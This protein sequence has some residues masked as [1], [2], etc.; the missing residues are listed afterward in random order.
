MAVTMQETMN[1]IRKYAPNFTPKIGMILGSGLGSIAD[2]LTDTIAVPYQAIPGLQTG[3]VQGH[4]SLM[5]MGNLGGVP[6]VCMKGRLHLYEGTPYESVRTFVR[7]IRNLGA[8]T[9]VI[10]GAAGSLRPEVG[11]GEVMLLNDHINFQPGNPLVGPNDESIGPRFMGMEDAYDEELRTRFL[12]VS[13]R[14]NIPVTEGVYLSLIGPS[15][16]TPAEIRMFQSWGADA[17]GMSVVPEVIIARHCGM[18]VLGLA[19]ITNLAA[20]LSNEHITH[21]G[22]LQFGEITARKLTKLIPE[23]IKDLGKE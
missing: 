2:Q 16:E 5:V 6:V 14:L 7:I 19:A 17:I 22:T 13:K 12:G 1:A 15:F 8:H 11:A 18:K 3:A 21:E 20:G 9:V 4:A 10:T 23:F